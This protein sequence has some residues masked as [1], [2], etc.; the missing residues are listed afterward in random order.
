LALKIAKRFRYLVNERDEDGLTGLQLLSCNAKAF[1]PVRSRGF[2]K[3]IYG[4][5][6][7]YEVY[8]IFFFDLNIEIRNARTHYINLYKLGFELIPFRGGD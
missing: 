6:K 2:L 7:Y 3:R 4:N 5:G 8:I 1:E